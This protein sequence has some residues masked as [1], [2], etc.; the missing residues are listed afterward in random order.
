MGK[1]RGSSVVM[2]NLETVEK[3]FLTEKFFCAH[4]PAVL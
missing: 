2:T 4:L 1:S 3:V